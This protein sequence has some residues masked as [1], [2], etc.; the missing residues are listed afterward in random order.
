[1]YVLCTRMYDMGFHIN[2]GIAA[3]AVLVHI[4][5]RKQNGAQFE[6]VHTPFVLRAQFVKKL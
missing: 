3:S 2:I 4:H 1:M 6:L 5:D